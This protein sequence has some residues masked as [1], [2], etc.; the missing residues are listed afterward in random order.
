MNS[1]SDQVSNFDVDAYL[2]RLG[3]GWK[4]PTLNFLK[5]ILKRHLI[6]IPF[7]NLDIHYGKRIILE[8]TLRLTRTHATS[9]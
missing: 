3:L 2:G 8:I 1:H 9:R 6:E 5:Q 4:S 7:E